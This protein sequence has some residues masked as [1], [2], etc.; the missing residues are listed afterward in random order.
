[1]FNVKHAIALSEKAA[2]IKYEEVAQKIHEYAS[3]GHRQCEIVVDTNNDV[4]E[5]VVRSVY[6]E[7]LACGFTARLHNPR[8]DSVY[9]LIVEW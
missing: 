8:Y 4:S 9:K 1:M 2:Q 7:L 5:H 3:R 6:D